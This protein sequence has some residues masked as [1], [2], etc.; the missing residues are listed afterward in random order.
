MDTDRYR[1]FSLALFGELLDYWVKLQPKGFDKRFNTS[2]SSIYSLFI[3]RK[4]NL[5]ASLSR[6]NNVTLCAF[7]AYVKCIAWSVPCPKST[8]AEANAAAWVQYFSNMAPDVWRRA[9]L[10][11]SVDHGEP[12]GQTA[13]SFRRCTGMI[14]FIL[15]YFFLCC[16]HLSYSNTMCGSVPGSFGFWFPYW[17]ILTMLQSCWTI[18]MCLY[19]QLKL[20]T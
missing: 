5:P 8:S 13:A 2:W 9:P 6:H 1:A 7:N 20:L 10:K 3:A 11:G 18:W 19:S 14:I 16:S 12:Q 17:V 4:T 15:F